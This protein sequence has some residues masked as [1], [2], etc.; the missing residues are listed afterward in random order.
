MKLPTTARYKGKRI[1]DIFL[2]FLS[3]IIFFIPMVL[4]F[5]IVR[6]SSNGEALYWSKR[7]GYGGSEFMMPK[8]RTMKKDTPVVATDL[9]NKPEIYITKIGSFLRKT[10]LDEL[11]QIWSVIKGDMSFVGP[12]PALFNQN[13][14]ILFRCEHGINQLLPGITGWAQVNGR[15]ELSIEAKVIYDA[16]Y[17]QRQSLRFDLKIIGLTITRVLRSQGVSH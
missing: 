12:R 11:P 10:S 7:I 15:D 6:T 3:T 2:I 14:L 13:E 4:I 1:L 8:F 17:L 9:L 5:L 16:E